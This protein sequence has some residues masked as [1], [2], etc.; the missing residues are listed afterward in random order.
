LRGIWVVPVLASILI[1][2]ISSNT[3]MAYSFPIS[4]F[5]VD[6]LRCDDSGQID[7][8]E[9]LG[10]AP[11]F[12]I[13][14]LISVNTA[15]SPSTLCIPDDGDALNDFFI[16]IT[17][18]TPRH[19]YNLF[20]VAD[21]GI[22]VG[23][24]DGTIGGDDAFR[25]NKFGVNPNLVFESIE[26]NGVFEPGET[27]TFTVSNFG[28][29][30]GGLT[31]T[32]GS[33]GIGAASTPVVTSTASIVG[34]ELTNIPIPNS[35]L[36]VDFPL[37]DLDGEVISLS[38][39]GD[40]DLDQLSITGESYSHYGEFRLFSLQQFGDGLCTA[41]L[42]FDGFTVAGTGGAFCSL[43]VDICDDDAGSCGQFADPLDMTSGGIHD[44]LRIQAGNIEFLADIGVTVIDSSFNSETIEEVFS[45]DPGPQ[46][47][48]VDIPVNG[49]TTAAGQLQVHVSGT[50]NSEAVITSIIA[51]SSLIGAP[52]AGTGTVDI[53]NTCGA[54]VGANPADT[55]NFGT[56]EAGVD[57]GADTIVVTNTG[58]QPA[59]TL[60]VRALTSWLATLVTN[61]AA[62]IGD[63]I[64]TPAIT[65]FGPTAAVGTTLTSGIQLITAAFIPGPFTTF[66]E[67][68]PGT[69]A[70]ADF[71]GNMQVDLEFSVTCP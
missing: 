28:P 32:F 54:T 16:S 61:S 63:T 2:G 34:S 47:L 64:Y 48:I 22:S 38:T 25:I 29:A 14:E 66:W 13:A 3:P 70:P 57:T 49:I 71:R 42:D 55:A 10:T 4:A 6:D 67:T 33:T 26:P 27:W 65:Q 1:I 21:P 40:F 56:M 36:V 50:T 7:V 46:I 68:T 9:E 53:D 20:F 8:T 52:G 44:Q 12:P 24:A 69:P 58:T 15:S 30:G 41:V 19:F 11:A 37:M 60:S 35:L 5:F 31:P 43:N 62:N 39:F 17:N 23:N 18:E 59:S 51:T 45:V